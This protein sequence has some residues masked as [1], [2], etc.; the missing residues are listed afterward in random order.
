MGLGKMTN[1]ELVETL[2]LQAVIAHETDLDLISSGKRLSATMSAIR[3]EIFSRMKGGDI[4]E[5]RKLL[6][7]LLGELLD[8][9]IR[10][11]F[12]GND[13]LDSSWSALIHQITEK[14]Q[15]TASVTA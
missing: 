15:E 14:M 3:N 9:S 10:L 4:R 2:A 5:N 12:D 13:P 8:L 7:K 1:E 6:E 11:N